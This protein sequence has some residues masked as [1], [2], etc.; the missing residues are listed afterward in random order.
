MCVIVPIFL[1]YMNMLVPIVMVVG[2]LQTNYGDVVKFVAV[3]SFM[4]VKF[5]LVYTCTWKI[6]V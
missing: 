5:L 3:P 6:C 1:I 4:C 2:S